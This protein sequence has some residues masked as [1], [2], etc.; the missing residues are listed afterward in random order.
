MFDL[1]LL[2]IFRF[3]LYFV[4]IAR[5]MIRLHVIQLS[6]VSQLNFF[7]LLALKVLVALLNLK[8]SSKCLSSCCMVHIVVGICL[9]QELVICIHG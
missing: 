2:D 4:F 1:S 7:L 9:S 8:I 3:F 5:R 6:S